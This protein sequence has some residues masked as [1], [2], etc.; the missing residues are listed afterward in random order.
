MSKQVFCSVILVLLIFSQWNYGQINGA[1]ATHQE[2]PLT[3]DGY[4]FPTF[5]GLSNYAWFK[6]NLAL[7]QKTEFSIGGEHYRRIYADRFS[8]PIQLKQYLDERTYILGGYQREWDLMNRGEGRPNPIPREDIFFGIGHD[9][10]PN[11]ML[12]AK[13]VVPKGDPQ[14]YSIGLEG[15]KN[16]FRLGTRLKF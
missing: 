9:V 15:V 12:E 13:M 1:S 10:Q 14:F 7:T 8:I 11:M 2:S 6:V 5:D 3:I 4:D 16:N